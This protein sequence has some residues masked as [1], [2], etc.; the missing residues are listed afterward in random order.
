MPTP[1]PVV[2]EISTTS[3]GKNH[4]EPVD[5]LIGGPAGRRCQV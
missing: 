1:A 2:I 3:A 4:L 5:P